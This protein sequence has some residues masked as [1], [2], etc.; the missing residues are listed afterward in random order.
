MS[1]GKRKNNKVLQTLFFRLL[2]VQVLIIASG[3]IN[4]IADGAVAGR[5]IG[6]DAVGV[7]G[8]FSSMERIFEAVGAVLI[9]GSAVLCGTSLGQGDHSR[10]RGIFSLNLAITVLAGIFLTIANSIAAGP[11]AAL[12]GAGT[13]V[14]KRA[15]MSYERG[16]AF[17]IIPMLLAQQLAAFLQMQS[18]FKRSYAGMAVMTGSNILFNL[19]FVT[20]LHMGL[21]GLA[22]ATSVSNWLYLIVL[23]IP[24]LKKDS[25]LS[26][27]FSE[28]LWSAFG[29][30]MTRGFPGALLVFCLAIR[31]LIINRLLLAYAGNT[32]LSAMSAFNMVTILLICIPMG[33]GSVVRMLTSVFIG[34]EDAASIRGLFRIVFTRVMAVCILIGILLLLFA[35]DLAGIFITDRTS[36][37]FYVTRRLFSLYS[38]C[39]P[40]VLICSFTS[41]YFQALRR[42]AFV[43]LVSVFDGLVS[44][45]VPAAILTPFLGA[46]GVW[47][48][49]VLGIVLTASL[50]PL[51]SVKCCGHIPSSLSECLLLPQVF[52]EPEKPHVALTVRNMEEVSEASREVHSFCSSHEISGMTALFSALCIEEMAGNIVRHGFRSGRSSRSIDIIARIVGKGKIFLR[53]RDDCIPFNPIQWAQHMSDAEP[54]SHIGIRMVLGMARDVEYQNLLGMNVL[55]MV[56]EDER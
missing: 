44:M 29:E 1:I 5:F 16:Y 40:F 26:F 7:I 33:T 21:F 31:Y 11:S 38:V 43:N 25:L 8:L 30:M 4:A 19:L 54:F 35:G 55:T 27:R 39:I 41:G 36:E 28:I 48:S 45:V 50:G 51:Y 9:G 34:E 46:E 17:G 20:K 3:S 52:P 13:P 53:V 6:A 32:G 22:L 37:V 18:C 47:I 15:L 49:L 56:V 24:F 10:T 12:M 2:P 14:L 42:K 23:I